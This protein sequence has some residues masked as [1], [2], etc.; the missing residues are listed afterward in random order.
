MTSSPPKLPKL[1]PGP[2]RLDGGLPPLAGGWGI[3]DGEVC[4]DVTRG[5]DGVC[6][7][8]E[9]V[10]WLCGG[11]LFA[12]AGDAPALMEPNWMLFPP[13]G[14]PA[15]GPPFGIY[16]DVPA[17]LI[18][19]DGFRPWSP[20]PEEGLTAALPLTMVGVPTTGTAGG[21]S[22]LPLT[23]SVFPC[24]DDDPPAATDADGALGA[25]VGGICFL[26]TLA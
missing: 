12:I 19:T 13:V 23:E 9:L 2:W 24:C 4:G 22:P 8:N 15:G 10:D 7:A 21:I 11:A 17:A 25:D 3:G 6:T 20:R 5:F 14:F 18:V 16:P 26:D 1:S